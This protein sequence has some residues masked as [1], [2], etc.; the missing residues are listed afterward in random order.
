MRVFPSVEIWEPQILVLP[1]TIWPQKLFA[2]IDKCFVRVIFTHL[3]SFKFGGEIYLFTQ[4]SPDCCLLKLVF[5]LYFPVPSGIFAVFLIGNL[6][7]KCGGL[8]GFNFND[9]KAKCVRFVELLSLRSGCSCGLRLVP[10]TTVGSI[11]P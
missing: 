9:V 10:L 2:N 3:M 1:S 8:S 6:L 11:V 4:L 5:L 7:S